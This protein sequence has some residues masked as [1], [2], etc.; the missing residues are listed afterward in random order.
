M[1]LALVVALPLGLYLGHTGRGS[2]L[3]ISIANVGRAVPSL[4]LIFFGSRS[5]RARPSS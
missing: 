2:F 4:A 5:S 3:A 1:S